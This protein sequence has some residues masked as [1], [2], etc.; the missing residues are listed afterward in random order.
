MPKSSLCGMKWFKS[1]RPDIV[2]VCLLKPNH[3]GP[4]YCGIWHL[5][6]TVEQFKDKGTY[7]G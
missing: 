5:I 3:N 2:H 4:H 1:A 7:Y 6:G